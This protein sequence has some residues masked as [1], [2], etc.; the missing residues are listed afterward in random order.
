[1]ILVLKDDNKDV[2]Q[3]VKTANKMNVNP[4]K[5]QPGIYNI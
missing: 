4:T 5:I 2:K 1:M 3:K